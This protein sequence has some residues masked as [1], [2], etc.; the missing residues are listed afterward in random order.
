MLVLEGNHYPEHSQI[1]RNTLQCVTAASFASK[2]SKLAELLDV[3][4]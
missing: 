2:V 1:L 4:A 3:C